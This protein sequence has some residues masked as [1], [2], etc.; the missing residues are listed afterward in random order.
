MSSTEQYDPYL[1]VAL[2][3]FGDVELAAMITDYMAMMETLLC[4]NMDEQERAGKLD[5]LL[6]LMLITQ[7]AL[8]R[9]AMRS[10]LSNA[11]DALR[12]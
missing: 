11:A 7:A 1:M 6:A 4:Q 9:R 8:H 10:L 2:T 12:S 5:H 3:R